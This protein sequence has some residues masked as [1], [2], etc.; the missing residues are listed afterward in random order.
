MEITNDQEVVSIVYKN[1]RGET[2]E[3]QIIPRKI[4]FG[5]TDW[6]PEKQWLLDAFD[7]G[8]KAD[9]SFAMKDISS[10]TPVK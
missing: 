3:R 6:H 5:G 1:Y 10:W 8:K 4:W 2:A 9:R 7:I